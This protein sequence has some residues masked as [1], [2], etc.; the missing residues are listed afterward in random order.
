MQ[1]LSGEKNQ[2][3]LKQILKGIYF[4]YIYREF[5]ERSEGGRNEGVP[6]AIY[7]HL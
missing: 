3:I 5:R 2:E 6:G 4:S 1:Q 7:D